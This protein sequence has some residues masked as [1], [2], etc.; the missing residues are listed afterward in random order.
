MN[1]AI[2]GVAGYVA[3]K[4]LVAI[5]ENSGQLVAAV[6]PHDCVGRLDS[7]F[8]DTHFFTEIERF[9]R[10]LEKRRRG[11]EA[12]RIQYVR[13][14]SPNYLHD[15]ECRLALRTGSH[16]ICEKPL[17]ISPWNLDG[18]EELE[19]EYGRRVYNVLQ[20]RLIPSLVELK[21]KIEQS[22]ANDK[23]QISLSYVTRRGRW[24][25]ASWKGDTAKSGGVGMNIGIH[26]FDLLLW[27]FG[28]AE[29]SKVH[30]NTARRMAGSLELERASVKW[31]LSTEATDLPEHVTKANG[32]AHRSM[33]YDGQEIEFKGFTDLHAAVYKEI[34]EGRG[35]GISDARPA[36]ELVHSIKHSELCDDLRDAHHLVSGVSDLKFAPTRRRAA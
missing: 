21:S 29:T 26:F 1:F 22:K 7:F 18:L 8:P 16:A 2:I 27:L 4:H 12:G 15:S 28:A 10:F 34:L 14:C 20:L 33:T 32:F 17:V 35:Y 24:Y 6:D 13:I 5:A 30:L 36:I 19:Q 9:D 25:D 23:A 3:H 11:A 31:F